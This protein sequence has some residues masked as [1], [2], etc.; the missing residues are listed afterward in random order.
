MPCN[1]IWKG[2]IQAAGSCH[3]CFVLAHLLQSRE[4]HVASI[5]QQQRIKQLA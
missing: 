5:Q 1:H 3:L 4:Q 2:R